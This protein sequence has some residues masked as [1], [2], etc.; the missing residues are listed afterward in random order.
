[1]SKTLQSIQQIVD[2]AAIEIVFLTL[3]PED[4]RELLAR[5]DLFSPDMRASMLR[6]MKRALEKIAQI[7]DEVTIEI[8]LDAVGHES[9]QELA[10]R[11]GQELFP[12]Y[13][14]D[15]VLSV[16]RCAVEEIAVLEG[17]RGGL[18]TNTDGN[19]LGP[20]SNGMANQVP[21]GSSLGCRVSRTFP[22]G[23]CGRKVV[24]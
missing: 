15:R 5:Q 10:A 6:M 14:L 9:A 11:L 21:G 13:V 19:Y 12:R 16:M 1:M 17:H 3:G 7:V 20:L 18:H 2:R 24:T 4:E 8:L 22:E 23:S